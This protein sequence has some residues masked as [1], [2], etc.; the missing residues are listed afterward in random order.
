MLTPSA[1]EKQTAAA[2]RSMTEDEILPYSVAVLAF[3]GAR[4]SEGVNSYGTTGKLTFN[5]LIS[6]DGDID[7]LA[8][9]AGLDGRAL[10]GHSLSHAD[11]S[12]LVNTCSFAGQCASDCVAESGN[13]GYDSVQGARRARTRLWVD[14][15]RA[16]L[17]IL[18]RDIDL[19]IKR[20]GGAHMVAVRLNAY[21]DIRWE[22]ILPAWFFQR[23][24]AVMFYD[25]TKHPQRSRPMASMPSNYVI[26][27][28]YSEKTTP[29]EVARNLDNGRNVA[30]VI[31]TRGGKQRNGTKRPIPSTI[32]GAPVVDGDE[33]D[34][35][36]SDP[37]GHVVAL[38]RKGTLSVD[39]PFVVAVD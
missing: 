11:T 17:S 9:K 29:A 28:S 27:Y 24:A 13:G 12:G 34:R 2:L 26:T 18:C 38:R 15:P 4:T 7:K 6:R 14:D 8:L 10:L 39:S 30:V 20:H 37:T 25:Y 31:S 22:R 35:R 1:F 16:A 23:Y 19:A 3:V 32:F 21:S 36:Y 33:H 5:G